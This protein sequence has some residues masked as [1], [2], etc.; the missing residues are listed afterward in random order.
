MVWAVSL[1]TMKLIPHSLTDSL[2]NMSIRSLLRFG[3]GFPART[4]T[5]LYPSMTHRSIA[6][7]QH[8]SE[9]TS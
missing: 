9:R 4:E 7:P 8:I 5:V 1:L 6:V 3:T 2:Y